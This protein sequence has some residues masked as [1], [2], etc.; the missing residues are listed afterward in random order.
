MNELT[1]SEYLQFTA[2]VWD[3]E[4]SSDLAPRNKKVAVNQ[5][6]YFPYSDM[7]LYWR[8]GELRLR[9]QM[10]CL[11]QQCSTHT[12]ATFKSTPYGVLRRLAYLISIAPENEHKRLNEL[13]PDHCAALTRAELLPISYEYPTLH[14]AI[15]QIEASNP[16]N[17][18]E[19]T[20]FGPNVAR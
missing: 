3:P 14:E 6:K 1:G 10:H 20:Y 12:N 18:D 19:A 2:D 17:N 8:E 13:Y 7:E 5:G 16:S 11:Y 4:A 15:N 9:F